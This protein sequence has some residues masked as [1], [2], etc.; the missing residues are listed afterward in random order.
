MSYKYKA[1]L[2][3]TQYAGFRRMFR[4]LAILLEKIVS[5]H[6]LM[7]CNIH[8]SRKLG[9]RMFKEGSN[10]LTGQY[11]GVVLDLQK[12]RLSCQNPFRLSSLEKAE[13]MIFK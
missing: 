4:F 9:K 11:F 7:S 12:A 6:L 1:I 2:L 10:G 3:Y 5:C 13:G 8:L